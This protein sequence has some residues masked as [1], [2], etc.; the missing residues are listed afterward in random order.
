M[1]INEPEEL[2]GMRA[3]G[4]VVRLMLEAMRNAVRPGITTAELD[5]VGGS[6]DAAAGRAVRAAMVYG[7]PGVNCISLNDEAVH[8]IP[9]QRACSRA[10]WS[11]STSPS[12]K[13]DSWRTPR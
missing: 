5:E 3:A 12:R 11:S 1:S 7:F 10:I 4:A 6:R 13:M 9:G 2:A 8:G